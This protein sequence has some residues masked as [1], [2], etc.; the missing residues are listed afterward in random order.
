MMRI[1]G[2]YVL[3]AAL[4]AAG[5]AAALADTYMDKLAK[6]QVTLPDNFS[7]T[8]N[9]QTLTVSAPDETVS[10]V[11]DS[12]AETDLEAAGKAIDRRAAE[13]VNELKFKG[14]PRK[15]KINGLEGVTLTGSGTVKAKAVRVNTMALITPANRVFF[16]ITTVNDDATKAAAPVVQQILSSIK[17]V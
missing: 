7:K 1:L 4:L 11:I 6:V 17:A 5:S 8:Q 15:V 2:K 12:L 14:S 3:V 9:G 10:M 16:V 13:K